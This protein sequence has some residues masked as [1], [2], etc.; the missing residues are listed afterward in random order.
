MTEPLTINKSSVRNDLSPH[1]SSATIAIK[2]G[3]EVLGDSRLVTDGVSSK[4]PHNMPLSAKHT[5]QTPIK[6]LVG[7]GSHLS[8]HG[9]PSSRIGRSREPGDKEMADF[10]IKKPSGIVNL[11]LKKALNPTSNIRTTSF[12]QEKTQLSQ[13]PTAK[14][15]TGTK[16]SS[17]DPAKRRNSSRGEKTPYMPQELF[18]P[19][20]SLQPSGSIKQFSTAGVTRTVATSK[21]KLKISGGVLAAFEKENPFSKNPIATR[22]PKPFFGNGSLG[23]GVTPLKVGSNKTNITETDITGLSAIVTQVNEKDMLGIQTTLPNVSSADKQLEQEVIEVEPA[24]KGTKREYLAGKLPF[25]LGGVVL[26][27]NDNKKDYFATLYKEHFRH[28]FFSLKFCKG[29]KA[30]SQA[31]LQ[32]KMK[33]CPQKDRSKKTLVLDLDETLIHCVTAPGQPADLH[34]P[35]LFPS[36][37]TIKVDLRTHQGTHQLE[38]ARQAVPRGDGFNL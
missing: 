18:G 11:K 28:T 25:Y 35:I 38:A 17:F 30:A 34:L 36:G 21:P 9:T 5:S 37:D 26:F 8:D 7:M 29:L 14:P 24:R 13:T 23:G 20:S 19:K 1:N 33:L 2:R 12:E 32:A 4:L 27:F 31:D 15:P 6:I 10:L 3:R 16:M 22:T